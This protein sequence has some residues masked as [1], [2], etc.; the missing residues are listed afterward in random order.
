MLV[1]KSATTILHILPLLFL[2]SLACT[3][4]Q[5]GQ[6]GKIAGTVRDK[7]TGERMSSLKVQH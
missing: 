5:A 2:L 4:L 6:T 7:K 3:S 1:M